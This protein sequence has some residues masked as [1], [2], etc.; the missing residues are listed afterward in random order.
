MVNVRHMMCAHPDCTVQPSFNV[1]G[2]AKPL[3]CREHKSDEMED[4]RNRMCAHP[5]CSTIPS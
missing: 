5:D 1:E 4:V 2:S 3:F